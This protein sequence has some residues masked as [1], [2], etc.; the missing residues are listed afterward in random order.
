MEQKFEIDI[1]SK[2]EHLEEFRNKK[3]YR[4]I[5]KKNAK[6]MNPLAL[7]GKGRGADLKCL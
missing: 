6:E 1:I 2:R 5:G 4:T 3:I 7:K